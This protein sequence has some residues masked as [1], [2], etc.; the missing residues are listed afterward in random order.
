MPGVTVPGMAILKRQD[1]KIKVLAGVPLFA[2]LSKKELGEIARLVTEVEIPPLD[3]LARQGE[4]GREAMVILSGKATVRRTGRK[5]AELSNGDVVGEISLLTNTPRN[6]S[7]R[8]D[9]VVS[10]LVMN[11]REFS[12]LV[13]LHP[14]VG[15]KILRTVAQR[16]AEATGAD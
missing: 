6:A 9:T 15:K 3:Y 5:I 16:L 1:D 4:A 11:T 2:G 7:V 13:D 10:A 12:S 14:Q 8:A